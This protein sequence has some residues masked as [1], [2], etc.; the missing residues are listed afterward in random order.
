MV[1]YYIISTLIDPELDNKLRK[2]CEKKRVSRSKVIREAIR[3]FLEE[4]SQV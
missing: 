1:K 3:K 2:Y 4:N